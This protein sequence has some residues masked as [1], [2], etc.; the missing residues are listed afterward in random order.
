MSVLQQ[1]SSESRRDHAAN[2]TAGIGFDPKG[3]DGN[4]GSASKIGGER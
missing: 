2:E 1:R 4:F 3:V